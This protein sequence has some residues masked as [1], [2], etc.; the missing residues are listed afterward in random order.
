MGRGP[1]PAPADLLRPKSLLQR[2]ARRWR[3]PVI[4]LPY[5]TYGTAQKL[6]VCGR[7]LEDEGFLPAA[8]ADTRWRNLVRFYKRLESDEVPGARL[9]ARFLGVETDGRSDGE[10]YFRI[11]LAPRGRVGPGDWQEVE[12]EL[13]ETPAVK[14]TAKVLVPSKRARFGV[15]SDIDDTIVSSHVTNK[16]KMIL[17]VALT[18]ARTRKP[19][20][21]VAAFYRALHAG[22]N[23][24]FYVSKSPWNLYAPLV[25]YLEVQGLPRGPLML[26]DF[27][28]RPEKEHKRKAIEDI[29]TTYPKLKFILIGDSGE[30]DPEIYSGIVHRFPDRIRAI[31]I[32]SVNQDPGRLEAIE[33]LIREVA[34][35]G[36]QLVLAPDS[37]P[38][39]AHAAAEGLIQASELRAV[40]AEKDSESSSSKPALSSG[41]LK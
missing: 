8:D 12:L 11:E 32:R 35:T 16:L 20:L 29:L 39:A 22:L 13:I 37:E 14:T 18:N 25:E 7:V 9:R 36:C 26:R 5:L 15:I 21:G 10:G 31:Y 38:A 24:F 6:A 2:L 33:R 34:K 17:T 19:F 23:P 28:F 4:I 3:D 41:A 27:G 1:G 40:R 30:E